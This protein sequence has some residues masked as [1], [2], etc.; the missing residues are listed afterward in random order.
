MIPRHIL[1]FGAGKVISVLSLSSPEVN[2]SDLEKAYADSIEVREVIL[3][4]SV[5]AGIHMAVLAGA[6][7]GAV[8]IGPAYTCDT[9]HQALALSGAHTRLVDPSPDSFL[10][11]PEA[12]GTV[13]EPDCVLLLSEVYGIPYDTET[14][15][16]KSGIQS[17]L[18]ILDLAMC[19]PSPERMKQLEAKDVALFSFGWGK[20]MY[21]GWGG[22]ACFHDPELAGRVR[23]I[24]DRWS[25]GES[26]SLSVRH[27]CL[28]LFRVT[29]NQR[30]IY[31]LWHQRHL[32]RLYGA[33]KSLRKEDKQL[34]A[35]K[36]YVPPAPAISEQELRPE[37]TRPMTPL[38]RKLALHNLRNAM[39]NI[40]LRRNQAELYYRLLVEPGIVQGPANK[41]LPQ[42]HFPIRLPSAVRD[43][44]CD[45]LRGRGVDT[46]KLFPFPCGLDRSLYPNA[47]EAADKVVTLPL[48][49]ALTLDE[50]KMV[51]ECVKDGLQALGC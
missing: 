26:L 34:S 43:R 28:T 46:G 11:S 42:S 18:R 20:P 14:I 35:R 33:V 10:M 27:A 12:I 3:L 9:V 49:P 51:A 21:A 7:P 13:A 23:E 22:I 37:W 30:S 44:M 6:R 36:G 25:L 16:E 47:A 4:P 29:A 50:V 1:P 45:F 2:S 8:V 32:Y 40:E 19:I 39:R 24:R 31:G 15:E 17:R 38:S 5:R 48:G 41:G